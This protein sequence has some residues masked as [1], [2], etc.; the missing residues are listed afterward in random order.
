MEA[1]ACYADTPCNDCL[2]G[3]PANM[4]QCN[5]GMTPTLDALLMCLN[6][7]CNA[8]CIPHSSCNPVTNQ[9]C[10]TPGDACD[11]DTTGVY[12]C[13]GPPNNVPLCKM[14]SNGMNGPFCQ[15]TLHCIE[16]MNGMNGQCTRYC[17][18]D[19]DCGGGTCDKSTQTDGVGICLGQLDAGVDAAVDPA[20]T[21]PAMAPSNG[22]CYTGSTGDAGPPPCDGGPPPSDAG[23]GG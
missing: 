3:T 13:F 20:C 19:G 15:A 7:K 10:T 1:A 2:A 22:C 6:T 12:V 9:G 17:C 21:A 16:D 11:L 5:K 4:N 23:G 14:C 18:N 8:E